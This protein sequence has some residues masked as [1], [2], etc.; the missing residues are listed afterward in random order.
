MIPSSRGRKNPEGRS[1]NVAL[2]GH[3]EQRQVRPQITE[4]V[5]REIAPDEAGGQPGELAGAHFN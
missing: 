2:N 3:D 4:I 1:T 5:P